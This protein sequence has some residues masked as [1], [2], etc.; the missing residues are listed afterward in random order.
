[1]FEELTVYENIDYFC[2]LYVKDKQERKKDIEDAI[3]LV[4]L[5]DSANIIRSSC[6]ADY[7]GD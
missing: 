1:M 2:G 4:G 6:R 7:S 3:A 5:D